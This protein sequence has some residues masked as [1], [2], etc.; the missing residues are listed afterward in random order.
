[1]NVGALDDEKSRSYEGNDAPGVE[2]AADLLLEPLTVRL[3]G[4]L[5]SLSRAMDAL[6]SRSLR[7]AS[8]FSS[9]DAG[10]YLYSG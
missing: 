1:M 2:T 4:L 7:R 9:A 10:L 5:N 6:A 3:G 8:R